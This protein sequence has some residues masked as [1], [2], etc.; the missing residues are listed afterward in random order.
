LT[1]DV[2]PEEAPEGSML[3]T[4]DVSP[5]EAPEGSLLL[6]KGVSPEEALEGSRT[7]C[8]WQHLTLS[9]VTVLCL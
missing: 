6:T 2:S 5:E 4:N 1:N 3:L 8:I 7:G 9:H